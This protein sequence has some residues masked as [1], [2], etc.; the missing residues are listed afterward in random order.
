MASRDEM[1]AKIAAARSTPAPSALAGR[2]RI[3][4]N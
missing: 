2:L 3:N 1:S 4:K